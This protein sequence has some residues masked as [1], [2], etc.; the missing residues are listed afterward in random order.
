MNV[1]QLRDLA[2]FEGVSDADIDRCA[3]W[4]QTTELLAGSGLVREDDFAYKFF[5]VLDGQVEVLRDFEHVADLGPGEFF[6]E[7]GVAA[8]GR[9]N[10]RVTATTRCEV[11]WMMPWDF[12]SMTEHVPLVAQRIETAIAERTPKD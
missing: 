9:R 2:L 7:M 4:F 11:A 10:A 12:Q 8:G 6:G 3:S 1:D 5:V